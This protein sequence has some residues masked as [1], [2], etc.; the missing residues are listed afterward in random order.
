MKRILIILITI[1]LTKTLSFSTTISNQIEIDSIVSTSDIKYANLIF[2]EHDKLLKENSLL[3]K[4]LNNYIV[5]NSQLEQTD[6]LRIKQIEE[7]NRIY[8]IQVENLNK[9]IHKQNK[10]IKCWKIGGITISAGLILL[11]LLK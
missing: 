9:E 11:L 1:L 4:Q 2:I 5:L 10:V 7:L 3:Y 8:S 6:S